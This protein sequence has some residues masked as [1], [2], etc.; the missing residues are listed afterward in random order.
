MTVA[1]RSRYQG[2]ARTICSVEVRP[3]RDICVCTTF[4]QARA[5]FV[6]IASDGKLVTGFRRALMNGL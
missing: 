2:S 3:R 5:A 6:Q 1:L 4:A